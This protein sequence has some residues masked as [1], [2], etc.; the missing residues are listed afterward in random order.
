MQAPD[1]LQLIAS[2]GVSGLVD[3]RGWRFSSAGA[4]EVELVT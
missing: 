4:T 3:L 2:I 1:S